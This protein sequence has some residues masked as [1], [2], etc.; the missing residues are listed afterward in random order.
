V[1]FILLGGDLFDTLNPSQETLHK[2]YTMFN[3]YIYGD[4]D[5]ESFSFYADFEANHVN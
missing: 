5:K 3:N 2:T 4:N 1:D